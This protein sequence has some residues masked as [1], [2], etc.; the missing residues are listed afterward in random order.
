[1]SDVAAA[2]ERALGASVSSLV[3]LHGG[4]VAAVYGATI[5][6]HGGPVDVVAKHAEGVALASLDV[7]AYMLGVLR[8]RSRLPVPRV[9]F[10]SPSLLVMQRMEGESRFDEAAQRHGAELLAELH[11]ASSDDG[12]FGLE[13]DTLIGGLAQPN[14]WCGSWVGFF[15]DRRLLHMAR[16]ARNE[17]RLPWDVLGR[18]ERLAA[19]LPRLIGEPE[20]PSLLHGDV[21]TTNVLARGGRLTAFLDPA[22]YFGH[23][24]IE[25][26]FITLFDTFGP[27]FFERYQEL[28]PIA[29][30]FFKERRHIY[31]LYPLLVHVRLFGGGYVGAV[32]GTLD[33]LGW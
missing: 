15:R 33:R 11:T 25:L 31:N 29:P 5:A 1:M 2:I 20:R 6:T 24:E 32:C 19:E 8:Q 13:R 3:P 17:G 30:G 21:W 28:S 22:V 23:R 14:G 16:A 26:A 4:C 7:E 10:A 18:I 12:R 9:L 27:A